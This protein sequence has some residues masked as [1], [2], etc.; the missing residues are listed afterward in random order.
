V[1]FARFLF[2]II[3]GDHINVNEVSCDFVQSLQKAQDL[4]MLVDGVSRELL[5]LSVSEIGTTAN[6]KIFLYQKSSQNAS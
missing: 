1:V 5:T 2:H 3:V 4:E 6:L